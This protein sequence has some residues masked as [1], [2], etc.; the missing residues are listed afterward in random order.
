MKNPYP[1]CTITVLTSLLAAPVAIAQGGNVA[2]KWQ[3]QRFSGLP[4][5][6]LAH[7][8]ESPAFYSTPTTTSLVNSSY[9]SLGDNYGARTRGYITPATTGLYTFWVSGDDAVSFSLSAGL[10]KWDA[11]NIASLSSYTAAN[12]FDEVASQRSQSRYLVAGQSYFVELLHKEGGGADHAAVSW[13]QHPVDTASSVNWASATQG[14]VATQSSTYSASNPASNVIDGNLATHSLTNNLAGSSL[15]VDFRQDRLLSSLDLINR[16]TCCQTRLSNFRVSLLDSADNVVLSKDYYTQSGSVGAAETWTLPATVLARRVRVQYLG[17]NRD[18]NYWLGIAEIQA[19]GPTSTIKN[20]TRE[21]G[22]VMSQSTAYSSSYPASLAADGNQNTFHH[23]ADVAGSFLLSDLGADRIID[24]VELLNRLDSASANRLSNFRISILSASNAVLASQD[25]FTASGHVKNALRW[26]L[27]TAVTGRKVKVELLGANRAGNYF[28]QIA[29]LNVWGRSNTASTERGHRAAISA[30]VMNSYD[31]ALTD[32]LDDDGMQDAIEL[33]YGLNPADGSDALGDLDNDGFTNVFEIRANANPAVKESIAGYLLDEIWHNIPGDNL[34]AA[35]YKSAMTRYPTALD[36]ISTSQ[37]FA[38]GEQYVRRVRGYLTAPVSGTYQFWGAAD[39]DVDLFLSTSASKFDRKLILDNKIFTSI[40]NYD[41]DISQKS[42]PVTL[43]A[44]QKYYFEMWHKEGIGGSYFS[45]AWKTPN[46]TRSLI[47]STYLSSY[48]GEANDQDDDYLKD[49][50]ELANGLSITDNGKSLGSIDGA[51][52]DL[53][54]DGLSNLEEQKNNTAAN[55]VD[56]DGDGVSDY[57]EVNF[58]GSATLANDIG[59]F[60]P[61]ATIAGGSFVSTFGQWAVESEKA[62]QECRRGSVTYALPI[63]NSGIHALKFDITVYREGDKNEQHDFHLKLNGQHLAYKTITILPDGTSTLAVLTP[64][65]QA[66]EIYNLELF[67][68]NSYNNRRVSVDQ[69]QILSAGGTDSN[70]NNIPD[71]T[72]IRVKDLNGLDTVGSF[73]SKTSPATIEGKA[74][75]LGM[76]VTNAPALISAPN[77]RFF[78]EISL[79]AGMPTAL[80]FS[81]ENNA[82][83]ENLNVNWLPTNLKTETSITIR[84]G[85]SLLLTAFNDAENASLE[86]YT[87]TLNGST[88]SNTADK[89]TEQHFSSPGSFIIT[90]THTGADD[91]ITS[92]ATTIHV[93]GK[94]TVTPPVCIV[95]YPRTWTAPT[96]PAG[97]SIQF[98]SQITSMQQSANTYTLAANSPISQRMI[99]K[100]ESGIILGVG[101]VLCASLRSN[102]ETGNYITQYGNPISTIELPVVTYGNMTNAT[103]VCE[104]IIGGVTFEDG[105]TSKTLQQSDF[106]EYNSAHLTFLKNNAAHSNCR[107]F[108]VFHNGIRIAYFN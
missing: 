74:K 20:W 18:N 63:A 36:H 55:L 83:Q 45:V 67:V 7:L 87:Y 35:G 31:P 101:E 44:G 107:R 57:D 42:S 23:T 32:D 72:E 17:P 88:I 96:I 78:T 34:T 89:P 25:Y 12:G 108:S 104:I 13:A 90:T 84:Q 61:V 11:R 43:V 99:M 71:W 56:S 16:Q 75:H 48:A 22:V 47:P 9:T 80:N 95:G 3:Q 27:P 59:A 15:T 65:L 2:G 46:G 28:M 85:D 4:G 37:A 81:F 10:S 58:F 52:G 105:S 93:L 39:S 70:S 79:T 6:S 21:V 82:L 68:D 24:S 33:T 40:Y 60:I 50:Y 94:V 8:T 76:V 91:I 73:H 30:S 98:D 62:M 1:F 100:S 77:G 19:F 5:S 26:D 106:N 14:S 102:D 41:V 69:L 92:T 54:G 29:E 86:S 66:G 103:V 53:D 51:Y 38:N 97:S 49:D 64:W